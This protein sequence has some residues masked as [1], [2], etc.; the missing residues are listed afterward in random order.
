MN[1]AAASRTIMIATSTWEYGAAVPMHFKTL[2]DELAQRGHRVRLFVDGQAQTP[3][4]PPAHT[5]Y[6]WP[7]RRPTRW[8]DAAFAHRI[9]SEHPP[10]ILLAN[11]GAVNVMTLV[12]WWHR[13][14][15]RIAWY[16]T[17]VEALRIDHK[18]SAWQRLLML[19][20]RL[21]YR[22]VT[23]FAPASQAAQ[24]DLSIYYGVPDTQCRVFYNPLHDPLDGAKPASFNPYQLVCVGRF[25]QVKG[26]DI[27]I[28]AAPGLRAEFPALKLVFVGDGPLRAECVALAQS[29]NVADACDF[30]GSVSHAEALR[31]IQ[32]AAVKLVPSRSDNC[33]LTVIEALA[34]GTPVIAARVGGIP[35]LIDDGVEGFLA[36]PD[37]PAAFAERIARVLR[38]DKLRQTLSENARQRFLARYNMREAVAREADWLE[39]LAAQRPAKAFLK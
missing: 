35:E 17:L 30:L 16:H 20:K 1:Q 36:P 31:Q 18:L 15:V 34:C 24:N 8:A 37:D 38:D 27:L 29:L 33:P 22:L 25:S 26:Q 7:S 3:N 4:G 28:R 12:G 9:F 32:T 6:V 5:T 14:P 2:A 19:R 23:H 21:V 13:V 10:D 39:Q 11:F